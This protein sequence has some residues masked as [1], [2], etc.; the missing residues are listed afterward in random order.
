MALGQPQNLPECVRAPHGTLSLCHDSTGQSILV[1]PGDASS[2][3]P[4]TVVAHNAQTF[5][6]G[7]VPAARHLVPSLLS[8]VKEPE[9]FEEA[10]YLVV[11]SVNRC[12][13]V[14]VVFR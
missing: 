11:W 9:R 7:E 1:R 3:G 5:Q 2:P 10:V 12:G 13:G 14:G 4:S 6:H 8:K